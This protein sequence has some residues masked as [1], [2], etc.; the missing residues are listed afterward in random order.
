MRK[1][2]RFPRVLAALLVCSLL[3]AG[4]VLPQGVVASEVTT[5]MD[6]V[7]PST[8]ISESEFGNY[9][10]GNATATFSADNILNVS[11]S[12][13][14]TSKAPIQA[15][16]Y[17][18]S[19]ETKFA[20]DNGE[21]GIRFKTNA[22]ATNF[23][24]LRLINLS[25]YTMGMAKSKTDQDIP[26]Y[27]TPQYSTVYN[28]ADNWM[29]VT[30]EVGTSKADVTVKYIAPNGA[31]T[32]H[33][34]TID[35]KDAYTPS[36][37]ANMS[38][39]DYLAGVGNY[40]A[41]YRE[42][43]DFSVR[44]FQVYTAP[45]PVAD[46]AS[47]L[48]P[49]NLL[50]SE[51]VFNEY[52]TDTNNTCTFSKEEDAYVMKVQPG[53]G[54][55]EGS[56]IVSK[57]PINAKEYVISFDAKF[58]AAD[59]ACGGPLVLYRTNAAT[60][61]FMGTLWNA[62]SG[63]GVS[64]FN[65]YSTESS[66]SIGQDEAK[67]YQTRPSTAWMHVDYIVTETAVTCI[68]TSGTGTSSYTVAY[69]DKGLSN[70]LGKH[71]AFLTQNPTDYYY[72]KN[73]QVYT[74]LPG[75]SPDNMVPAN[76]FY[77]SGLYAK[78]FN[79]TGA[80]GTPGVVNQEGRLTLTAGAAI[81]VKT[82][83]AAT[84]Y[85][86]SFDA[87]IPENGNEVGIRFKTD[88]TGGGNAFRGFRILNSNWGSVQV[89]SKTPTAQTILADNATPRPTSGDWMNVTVVVNAT[90]AVVTLTSHTTGKS[91]TYPEWQYNE[92]NETLGN[93]VTIFQE[94]GTSIIK[95]FQ[96]TEAKTVTTTAPVET[97]YVFSGYYA[98]AAFA[99]PFEAE[100]G[101][102]YRKFV[103]ANVLQVKAQLSDGTDG[104]KN[105][106]FV[107]SV[108]DLSY[109]KVGF[110]ITV[111]NKTIDKS[112]TAVYES[113]KAGTQQV[114]AQETFSSQ[115]K[116]M[117]AYSLREIPES[118]FDTEIEVQAYWYTPE[119]IQVYGAARTVTVNQLMA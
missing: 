32:T 95:N 48:Y 57:Q 16:T 90:T 4:I 20:N 35:Y 43:G 100:S 72:I 56:G 8:L 73:L 115:S 11:G 23:Y 36:A 83:V 112:S 110:K 30:I 15:D 78:Y 17:V 97:G 81:P 3:L 85:T 31:E 47:T 106:R 98:D 87:L 24:G 53:T 38:Y 105:I 63:T 42:G 102:A 7:Y 119:G 94:G 1:T 49:K 65:K 89:F 59:A 6:A 92:E 67:F 40:I 50:A 52:F 10:S 60:T 41:F 107:T 116:Y 33:P 51:F 84:S 28:E 96:I 109:E 71:I 34:F 74:E 58:S 82:A 46:V 64:L 14:L 86:I 118:A 93:Y 61:E 45:A 104:A 101:D 77:N 68:F 55:V 111:G 21:M 18:I 99:T 5:G 39:E 26:L 22:A 9:F 79:D 19:F 2:R 91:F 76:V 37:N 113:L 114:N 75:A 44:N 88:A 66:A 62:Y 29:T 69:A 12:G 117:S 108:D 13:L 25:G 80:K 103:D 27:G 70:T 54:C